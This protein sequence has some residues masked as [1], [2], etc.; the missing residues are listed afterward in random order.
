MEG[1]MTNT[2]LNGG[3]SASH[4]IPA[5]SHEL[6]LPANEL[7]IQARLLVN[8]IRRH[9]PD[10]LALARSIAKS[11]RWPEPE[12]WT[13]THCMNVVS[14]R[15]GFTHWD[16]ARRVLAG[17]SARGDDVGTLWYEHACGA[18]T[19]QWFARYE[20]ARQILESDPSL[21]LLPYRHQYVLVDR[22]F[23]ELLGLDP[24]SRPW[25]EAGRDLAGAYASP[26]WNALALQRLRA[27]RKS[28]TRAP[29]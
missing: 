3:A 24:S 9:N 25:T 21:Y 22:H 15:S 14:A 1:I 17:E 4:P 29:R 23:I 6:P 16:H 2:P 13:L 26:A 27:M 11:S 7:K 10:A 12:A 18:L 5:R 28:E 19:N 8:A 20:E